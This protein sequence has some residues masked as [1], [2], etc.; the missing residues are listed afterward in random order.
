MFNRSGAVCISSDVYDVNK[1]GCGNEMIR[2]DEWGIDGEVD[3]DDMLRSL[4]YWCVE[5]EDDIVS[6][7]GYDIGG[8]R[9][10][11]N[12]HYQLSVDDG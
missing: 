3:L 1:I 2:D 11:V 10:M 7:R 5:D 9:E 8:S 6:E 4:T 12:H